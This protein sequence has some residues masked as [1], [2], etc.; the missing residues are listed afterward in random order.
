LQRRCSNAWAKP[1]VHLLW[2]FW[3]WGASQTICPGWPQTEIL[4]ISASQIAR[5][6]GVSHQSPNF[7]FHSQYL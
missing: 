4:L 1:P 7:F 5:I 3:R 6:T 2:L